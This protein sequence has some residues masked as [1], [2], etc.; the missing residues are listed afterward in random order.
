MFANPSLHAT[1]NSQGRKEDFSRAEMD[2][3]S[4]HFNI[5]RDKRSR[6]PHKIKQ[7]QGTFTRRPP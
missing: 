4:S 3:V 2:T 5:V 1:E 7:G 6:K